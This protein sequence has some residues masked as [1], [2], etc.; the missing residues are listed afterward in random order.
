MSHIPKQKSDMDAK[1]EIQDFPI[2]E[3][4]T[5]HQV[6]DNLYASSYPAIPY[7]NA[8]AN[9]FIYKYWNKVGI[10][11]V[12]NLTQVEE[13]LGGLMKYEAAWKD[14]DPK[15][16]FIQV[17]IKDKNILT[18]VEL[19]RVVDDLKT[20]LANNVK[21]LIHC[22]Q[23]RGRTASVCALLLARLYPDWSSEQILQHINYCI[24]KRSY[25]KNTYHKP[26]PLNPIQLAQ[27]M[28]IAFPNNIKEQNVNNNNSHNLGDTNVTNVVTKTRNTLDQYFLGI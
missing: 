27:F 22:R 20:K 3:I 1:N 14:I 18:D 15:V 9:K 28:R 21:I 23:G 5:A 8:L 24:N 17:G 11:V 4:G 25:R 6:L 12:V 26:N 13:K 16:E 19:I 7:K 2:C 10:Q